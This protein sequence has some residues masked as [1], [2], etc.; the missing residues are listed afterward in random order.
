MSTESILDITPDSCSGGPMFSTY[1]LQILF[2]LTQ[3]V[4]W[5]R[6]IWDGHMSSHSVIH[7]HTSGRLVVPTGSRKG[8]RV[9]VFKDAVIS[10]VRACC[11]KLHSFGT[12]EYATP[13][14]Q[15]R[16]YGCAVEMSCMASWKL[17][18]TVGG[19]LLCVNNFWHIS[20]GLKHSVGCL[21][22]W[23]SKQIP[24]HCTKARIF[25]LR[26]W[27]TQ[28]CCSKMVVRRVAIVWNWFYLCNVGSS[29]GVR[30]WRCWIFG[31]VKS[32][33]FLHER[34]GC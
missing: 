7:R 28:V 13:V 30:S 10:A 20:Y 18:A 24:S 8:R 12:I 4:G 6:Q 1:I 33:V 26:E 23:Q 21:H 25:F 5:Y 17:Q 15:A 27:N 2:S 9:F 31:F 11:R 14:V 16:P 22:V 29:W 19:I 32:M 34:Y 3:V